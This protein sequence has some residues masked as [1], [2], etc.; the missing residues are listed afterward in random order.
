MRFRVDLGGKPD[1]HAG[2]RREITPCC[3]DGE[4]G[5]GVEN[6][7]AGDPISWVGQPSF[8]AWKGEEFA[9]AT[10]NEIARMRE[11]LNPCQWCETLR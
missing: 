7:E 6:R 2:R 3:R 9:T 5:M 4:G 1:H 10:W 8:R 11:G